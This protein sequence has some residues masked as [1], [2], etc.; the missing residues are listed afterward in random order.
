MTAILK[1]SF[2]SPI[3]TIGFR[4]DPGSWLKVGEYLEP[5]DMFN[6]CLTNR[7][8]YHTLAKRLIAQRG[9]ELSRNWRCKCEEGLKS[10]DVCYECACLDVPFEKLALVSPALWAIRHR[11][12]E[13]LRL[14]IEFGLDVDGSFNGG[15]YSCQASSPLAA[16]IHFATDTEYIYGPYGRLEALRS[17][18]QDYFKT[19]LESDYKSKEEELVTHDPLEMIRF[20]L[21]LGASVDRTM[22]LPRVPVEN[23]RH[24]V[25]P[26]RKK[27]A[28]LL[29]NL[30]CCHRLRWRGSDTRQEIFTFLCYTFWM[31]ETAV[32]KPETVK[33]EVIDA[34]VTDDI[35]LHELKLKRQKQHRLWM[36]SQRLYPKLSAQLL[37][38]A[39]ADR[40]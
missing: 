4:L 33:L 40:L 21:D 9:V 23:E 1:A 8:I 12:K 11:R 31:S 32:E 5:K 30:H 24:K 13:A 34:M 2:S 37:L 17:R 28:N 38:A 36:R 22:L 18:N 6:F 10:P 29:Q 7:Y 39:T 14:L 19:Q 26:S 35:E 25:K 3:Q 15:W 27:E 20:L 16:A